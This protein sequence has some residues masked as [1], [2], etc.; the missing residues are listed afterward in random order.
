MQFIPIVMTPQFLLSGVLFP[1]EHPA[2]RAAAVRG[3]DAGHVRGRRAA[4]GVHRRRG[5]LQPLCSVGTSRCCR[6]SRCP[7]PSS[8]RSRSAGTSCERGGR[9]GAGAAPAAAPAGD[10]DRRTRV[11]G[12][13]SRPGRPSASAGTTAPPSVTSPRA[14]AWTPPWSITTSAPSSS[15]SSPRAS[16]RWTSPRSSRASSPARARGWASGSCGSC[17]ETWDRPEVRPLL[18]GH[19]PVRDHGPGG[20]RDDAPAARGGPVPGPRPGHRPAGRA[21]AGDARRDA[22]DRPGH[23][24]ATWSWSSRWRR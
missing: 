8:A 12:S 6:W 15:C 2:G 20:G 24:P 9:A 14:R 17:V 10:R 16:S 22:A 19:R 13:C 4:P 18:H 11:H 23:G 7:S 21:T 5:A 3:P 1:V